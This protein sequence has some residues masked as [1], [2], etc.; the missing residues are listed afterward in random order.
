MPGSSPAD[1][2]P[3]APPSTAAP[4]FLTLV[5]LLLAAGCR[6]AAPAAAGAPPAAEARTPIVAGRD[7]FSLAAAIERL[8]DLDLWPGFAPRGIPL[9]I[10]D[11]ERTL[12]F[13]HPAPPGT[14]A[15]VAA[16]EGVLAHPGRHPAVTANGSAEI[17]GRATATI[18][19]GGAGASAEALV[20]TAAHEK[21]HVFQRER[22]PGWSANEVELFTYPASDVAALALR[23]LESDALRRA[24]AAPDRAAAACW[25]GLAMGLRRERY[26]SLRPGAVAWERK[27]ELAEGLAEYVERRALASPDT[28]IVPAEDFPPD[29]LRL[30]VYRSGAAIGRLLDRLAPAWRDSLE[31]RDST[32]RDATPLD[33]LLAV[34][35]RALVVPAGARVDCAFERETRDAAVRGAAR[36]VA[37]L[38]ERLARE[39][40]QLLARSGW[41]IEFVAPG[42]PLFPKEFDP[43]NVRVVA[44]GEVAHTRFLKL[45]NRG[46]TIEMLG[47][48]ALTVAAGAHPLFD[49]VRAVTITGL[50][51]EPVVASDGAAIT[52]RAEGLTADVR[53]AVVQDMSGRPVVLLAP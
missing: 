16:R 46:A 10:Y 5:A 3:A 23:R 33:S 44:P 6:A 38:R 47:A 25:S 28:G 37:A 51:S 43:L 39:R 29:D 20:G 36:D 9:A 49:G 11:G 8:G 4:H 14:F 22:H 13:D 34:A 18:L 53:G 35:A 27:G 17:G 45:G 26:A 42:E 48:G 52:I 1:P 30:R 41:R 32:A 15:P 2:R 12:L 31:R 24:L 50:G 40:E 7:P 21:F 19:L